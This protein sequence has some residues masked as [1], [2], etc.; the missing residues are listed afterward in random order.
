MRKVLITCLSAILVGSLAALL[1]ILTPQF[2]NAVFGLPP[3]IDTFS[4]SETRLEIKEG[5]SLTFSVSAS[6]PDGDSLHFQWALSDVMQSE[7]S[8]NESSSDNNW[9]YTANY[10]DRGECVV[11][12]TVSDGRGQSA[13]ASWTVIAR[14]IE[15]EITLGQLREEWTRDFYSDR[16]A[17]KVEWQ[18]E[19]YCYGDTCAEN[20][21]FSFLIDGIEISSSTIPRIEPGARKT[22]SPFQKTFTAYQTNHNLKATVASDLAYDDYMTQVSVPS[23][24]RYM[25][26]NIAKLFV[27]P[28]DPEVTKKVD[29]ILDNKPFFYTDWMAIRDYV[30]GIQYLGDSKAYGQDDYWQL[31]YETIRLQR[32]DCEDQA[33][34]LCTMLRSAGWSP[35]NVYVAGG[36]GHAW[37]SFKVLDLFGH[38]VWIRLEPTSGGILLGTFAD[39][40]STLI[41]GD[42]YCH[43]NDI[44]YQET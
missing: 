25:P 35:N 1:F 17:W 26:L 8:T 20:A 43:F 12:C 28:D 29:G 19:I 42:V 6:D 40:I 9:V 7:Y 31:P 30:G 4:P 3:T 15:L 24:P 18:C 23:L 34:L 41:G 37:V 33:I 36:E 39:L 2:K 14:Y 21:Q 10:G 16:P 38:P 27:T 11:Q 44:Y 22:V 13:S 5:D 32:G